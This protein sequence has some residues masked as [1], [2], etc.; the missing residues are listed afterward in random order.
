MY[1]WNSVVSKEFVGFGIV[2]ILLMVV[3]SL[4]GILPHDLTDNC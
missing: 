2:D 3:D 1:V 4:D